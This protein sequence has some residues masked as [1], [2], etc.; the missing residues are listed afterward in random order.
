MT[1]HFVFR[2]KGGS[3]ELHSHEAR[4]ESAVGGEECGQTAQI[5]IHK[6]LQ[7]TLAHLSQLRHGNRQV[8]ESLQA[9]FQEKDNSRPTLA[10][11]SP[12]KLPPEMI[13]SRSAKT[14]GLSVA[15]FISTRMMPFTNSIVSCTIPCTFKFEFL[16]EISIKFSP[17]AHISGCMRPALCCSC[18]VTLKFNQSTCLISLVVDRPFMASSQ[19]HYSSHSSSN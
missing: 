16:R 5:V 10:G 3:A 2:D 9:N 13:S 11:Y 18:G 4:V 14:S 1:Q 17:E 15:E 12:W 19:C 7:T 8:V 6:S